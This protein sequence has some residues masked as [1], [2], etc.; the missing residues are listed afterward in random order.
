MRDLRHD[1]LNPFIGACVDSPNICII[2]QYCSK[3]SLQVSRVNINRV[4]QM[5]EVVH[6]YGLVMK[7]ELDKWSS[8]LCFF[9]WSHYEREA[10][11][12]KHSECKRGLKPGSML[13]QTC[14]A[15]VYYPR[16]WKTTNAWRVEMNKIL[17]LNRRVR[18]LSCS[19]K[20]RK[21][22]L[23]RLLLIAIVR[24]LDDL[25]APVHRLGANWSFIA[26]IFLVSLILT[27]ALFALQDILEN[28]DVK[29]DHMFIASLVSDI[30]KVCSVIH[31][32]IS[33]RAIYY[34][35]ELFRTA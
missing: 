8:S 1:N 24:S 18:L 16:T 31:G 10:A 22:L 32:P 34:E 19:C 3:G 27:N 2:S 15:V 20:E 5:N 25:L 30:V 28:E 11:R 26:R 14:E 6:M 29:L 4:M 9:Y 23:R 12:M 17:V 21:W 33:L 35:R 7:F 13:Y